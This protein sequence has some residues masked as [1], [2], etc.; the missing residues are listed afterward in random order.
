MH[1]DII[2]DVLFCSR[3]RLC[4]LRDQEPEKFLPMFDVAAGIPDPVPVEA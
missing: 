2:S 4:D 1:I 3:A